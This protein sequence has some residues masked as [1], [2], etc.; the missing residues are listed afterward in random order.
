MRALGRRI[1]GWRAGAEHRTAEDD[2]FFDVP[3]TI[4]LRSDAFASG[5]PLPSSR[6]SPPLRWSGVPPEA[7]CLA[8]IVE[9]VDVP[10]LRPRV[11]AIAYA[12]D[13]AT[14]SFSEGALTGAQFAAGNLG[15]TQFALGYNGAGRRAYEAPAPL[16]GHGLHRYVFTLLAIDFTPRFDQPPTKGRLLDAISGHVISLG[17]LV[18]TAER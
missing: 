10:L 11:H 3:H 9:D 2:R 4:E 15:R 5:E 6:L 7:R 14:T 18:G 17:E 13:P 16:P 8:L 1:R 12:I